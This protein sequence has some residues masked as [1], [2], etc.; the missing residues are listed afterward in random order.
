MSMFDEPKKEGEVQETIV[1]ADVHLTGDLNSQGD[2]TI[3]GKVKGQVK[4]K[5]SAFINEGSLIEGSVDGQNI[6]IDGTIKGNVTAKEDLEINP[7]GKV[8]GDIMAKALIIKKGA[9]FIGNS[10]S[11]GE[12]VPQTQE[13]PKEEK[14]EKK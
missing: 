1:G 10:K 7:T 11:L 6:I 3:R 4:T 14:E 13:K 9:L 2:I 8:Y 5:N 12:E